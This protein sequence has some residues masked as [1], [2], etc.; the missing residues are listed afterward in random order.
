LNANELTTI[1][2]QQWINVHIYV[3]EK[4]VRIPILL[5]LQDVEMCAA[6]DNLINIILQNLTKFKGLIE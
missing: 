2:N 6:T 4:V 3:I 5:S 1:D